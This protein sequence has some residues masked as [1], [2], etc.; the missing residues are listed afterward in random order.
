MMRSANWQ[1][2][3]IA[4][5]G[6]RLKIVFVEILQAYNLGGANLKAAYAPEQPR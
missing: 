2:I 6:S 5:S 3:W 4:S 1:V